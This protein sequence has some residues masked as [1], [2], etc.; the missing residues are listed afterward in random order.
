MQKMKRLANDFNIAM[1]VELAEEVE[2]MSNLSQV[3]VNQ[4]IE[5]GEERGI[6]LGMEQGNANGAKGIIEMGQKFNIP[7]INILEQLQE[8]LNISLEQAKAYL[9]QFSK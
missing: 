6:K 4:G 1:T 8:S 2:R 7:T 9:D 5:Q 3:L